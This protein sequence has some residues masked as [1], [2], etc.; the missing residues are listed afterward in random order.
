ME[1]DGDADTHEFYVISGAYSLPVYKGRPNNE[2]VDRLLLSTDPMLT[3]Q[4]FKHEKQIQ[5][6][7]TTSIICKVVD[8]QRK[9]HFRKSI[10][11]E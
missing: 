4:D 8:Q 9:F 5:L 7:D 2:M 11:E 3:M 10:D 6:I 1:T